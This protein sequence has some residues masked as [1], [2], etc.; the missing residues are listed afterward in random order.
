MEEKKVYYEVIL[1]SYNQPNGNIMAVVLT[2]EEYD[3]G[4]K[5]RFLF[6]TYQEA[7]VVAMG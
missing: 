3:Q 5:S 6:E 2:N 1:D 4:R 7:V